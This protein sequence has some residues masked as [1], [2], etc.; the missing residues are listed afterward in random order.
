MSRLKNKTINFKLLILC[1]SLAFNAL[2]SAGICFAKEFNF[3]A[4]VDRNKLSLGSSLQLA[5]A[6]DDVQ[7]MPV[8][9]LPAIDGFQA[10]YLGPSTMMSIVNGKSSSSITHNYLLLSTKVGNFKIGP[11]KIEHS[12]DRYTSNQLSVEVLAGQVENTS[13]PGNQAEPLIKDLNDR[14]FLIIQTK[15]K[16]AY[17]N[18]IIPLTIKLYINNLGVRDIQYPE[19]SHE[20]F[21]VG[22]FDK[23]NQ[24][25]EVYKGVNFDVLEFNTSIFGLRPGEFK[26]GPSNIKCNLIIQKQPRGRSTFNSN[27][28]DDFF[29]RQEIYPVNLQSGYIALT[30]LPLPAE[31]RPED[32]SGTLG[33]FN[34]EV[35]VSPLEVKVGDPITLTMVVSGEGNLDTVGAPKLKSEAGFKI[36]EP[37]I[38]QAG[39]QKSFEQIIMPMSAQVKEV[40]MI[41]LAFFNIQSG[42]YKTITRGPFPIV[43][44]KPEKEEESKVVENKLPAVV[45]A[46]QEEK[47]GRDII[48]IKENCGHLAR[49][50]EYLYKNRI[51]LGLQVIPLLIYL[52]TFIIY[53]RQRRFK[54]DLKYARQL[55][56]PRKAR[57]GI[58]QAKKYLDKADVD[59][60]YDTL[61]DTMQE[62]LGDRLHLPSKGITI[63]VIDEH[64]GNNVVDAQV[65]V[66]LRD[67]FRD[68]DMVRYASSQLTGENM[69]DS[70]KK[71]EEVID[72]LQRQKI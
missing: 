21:S 43:I 9:E 2:S 28:F 46:V 64:L 32:F 70:L 5:L 51:F 54:T 59:K 4:T 27:I 44:V 16:S 63:S 61:F 22:R 56:A 34:L 72:Y 45:P 69:R 33:N 6:F 52:L 65:L 3:E 53:K 30:V 12:G 41:S 13:Q 23:P 19:F 68:C 57:T 49:K 26:L 35:S 62:Y 60:F 17:L 11:F 25:Q 42:E 48:Y 29:G 10:R 24:Y 66:K 18:E 38:K 31:N 67:I 47:L 8:P 7:N 55:L 20:G 58:Y 14:L 36:Y 15:K 40:P 1:L 71:L 37:Q 39:N 50:G